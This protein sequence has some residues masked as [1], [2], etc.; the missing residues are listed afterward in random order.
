MK[1]ESRV[2]FSQSAFWMFWKQTVFFPGRH[3]ELIKKLILSN[4]YENKIDIR[5]KTN[6]FLCSYYFY[7]T[8]QNGRFA[9]IFLAPSL[10]SGNLVFYTLKVNFRVSA[11]LLRGRR[12]LSYV[13]ALRARVD[14]ISI[15]YTYKVQYLAHSTTLFCSPSLKTVVKSCLM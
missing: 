15:S 6:C 8:S 14:V 11:P 10:I 2:D 5:V 3:I 4:I 9:P 13:V 12:E 7:I 1:V